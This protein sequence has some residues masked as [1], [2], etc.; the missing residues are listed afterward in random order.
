MNKSIQ[1]GFTLIELLVV[2]AIIGILA[3]ILFIA[4]NPAE[5]TRKADDASVKTALSQLRTQAAVDLSAGGDYSTL[6][7]T[8]D[9]QTLY[10]GAVS[11]QKATAPET[12]ICFDAVEEYIA[13]VDTNNSGIFCVDLNGFAGTITQVQYDAIADT[14]TNRICK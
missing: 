9:T 13:A 6:C 7:T 10:D 4:I 8:G 11:S 2:I 1:K 3:G 12:A 14:D 5:Q